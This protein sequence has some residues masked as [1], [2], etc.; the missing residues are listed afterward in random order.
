M[1]G[2]S[3][4]WCATAVNEQSLVIQWAVCVASVGKIKVVR[5]TCGKTCK[6]PFQH[7][8]EEHDNCIITQDSCHP[9]C[10]TEVD[11][12][13]NPT[14]WDV[15]NADQGLQEIVLTVSGKSCVFPFLYKKKWLS[16]CVD[17]LQ[18]PWCPTSLTEQGEPLDNDT[19]WLDKG[20]QRVEVTEEGRPCVF[21][22]TYKGK[23]HYTCM[24]SGDT[25]C[26]T[27]VGEDLEPQAWGMCAAQGECTDKVC[28]EHERHHT[29]VSKEIIH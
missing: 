24:G 10:P 8:D 11:A 19:C 26:A 12:G 27:R 5:T 15:C 3:L 22:F 21:P 1:E 2:S 23:R 20:Y 6:F 9:T 18:G 7:E 13:G 28:L 14:E 29:S 16:K 17:G 4:P 25:W